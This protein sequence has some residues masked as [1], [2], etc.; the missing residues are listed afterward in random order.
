MSRSDIY[1]LCF[2][3]IQYGQGVSWGGQSMFVYFYDFGISMFWPS[4]VLNQR[5]LS[6][7]E[8]HTQVVWVSLF[9]CGCLFPCVCLSPH[10]TVS[11]F[12]RFTFI[13]FVFIVFSLCF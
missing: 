6:L 2:V 12:V 9:V 13:V 1:F 5:Q 11:V 7:I 3:V 8:N 4:M 10:G